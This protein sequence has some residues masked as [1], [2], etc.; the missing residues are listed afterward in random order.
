MHDLGF[1]VRSML[2]G[3]GRCAS[4]W[5]MGPALYDMMAIRVLELRFAMF[6]FQLAWRYETSSL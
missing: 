4:G 5:G 2:Q 1:E 3:S 6:P